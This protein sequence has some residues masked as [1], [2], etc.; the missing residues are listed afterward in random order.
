MAWNRHAPPALAAGLLALTLL[1]GRSAVLSPTA[2]ADAHYAVV[3]LPVKSATALANSHLENFVLIWLNR[4]RAAHQLPPL[5]ANTK[6]QNVARAYGLDMFAQGYLSHVSRDGRSLQDR[7]TSTGLLLR[8]VGENLAYAPSIQEAEQALWQSAPH[9]RNILYRAF[10]L[11][12]VGVIDGGDEGL[13]V[14]QDFSDDPAADAP[15]DRL[16]VAPTRMQSAVR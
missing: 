11:V 2:H 4:V 13:I 3:S 10:R 5:R 6:I 12:G 16:S 14:V 8:V 9:R 1:L 15:A 7:L